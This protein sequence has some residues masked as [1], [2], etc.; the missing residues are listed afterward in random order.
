MFEC[1]LECSWSDSGG[2]GT[3][4]WVSDLVPELKNVLKPVSQAL[5]YL[6]PSA[7]QVYGHHLTQLPPF[8]LDISKT[9]FYG[10][11]LDDTGMIKVGCHGPTV[12]GVNHPE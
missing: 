9:G 8:S 5:I 4:A 11:C 10:F 6:K 3:G 2:F 7:A 12:P 1:L